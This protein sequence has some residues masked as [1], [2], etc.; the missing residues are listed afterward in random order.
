MLSIIFKGLSICRNNLWFEHVIPVLN[1]RNN[2]CL[3]IKRL[4]HKKMV[5]YLNQS[6]AINIDKDLFER[7]KFS[8]DQLMELAGQSCAIAIAKSYPLSNNSSDRI[9]ICCGPGNNGG[10]GLVCAR[11]LKHFGYSPEIYY[12]KE[13][14]NQLYKNLLHQ[15]KENDITILE[16]KFIIDKDPV[17]L[18]N[19]FRVIVD[20]LFGFSFKPPVRDTF[21]PIMKILK[22]A[23]IP[24]CSIDIPSG[25]DVEN[26]PS[27][28]DDICPEML[29]SLTAPKMCAHKFKGKFHYLGGRFVPKK[30]A[31]AYNL[32]LPMY[33]GTDLIVSL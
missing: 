8:L 13:T 11:H 26:G 16:S 7:Y 9:L 25:W 30:L 5:K 22:A 10:D 19:G 6:E 4:E 32:N 15:C 28:K 24:I 1:V 2:S 18:L 27:L 17:E 29:I 33:P 31:L 21:V 3:T 20:A 14:D 23:S 12:P